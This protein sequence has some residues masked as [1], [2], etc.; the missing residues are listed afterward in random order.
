[1]YRAINVNDDSLVFALLEP[2]LTNSLLKKERRKE[3]EDVPAVA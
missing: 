2:I 3:E 1:M